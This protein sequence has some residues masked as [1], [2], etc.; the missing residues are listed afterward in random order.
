VADGSLFKLE[1]T[2]YIGSPFYLY[3]IVKTDN[4]ADVI[5][6]YVNYG[7]DVLTLWFT[8]DTLTVAITII[9]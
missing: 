8:D 2:H 4:N 7:N 5:V 6:E 3:G 1:L 9:G